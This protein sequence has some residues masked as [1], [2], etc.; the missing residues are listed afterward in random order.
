VNTASDPVDFDYDGAS[1]AAM[2]KVSF[3]ALG[4]SGHGAVVAGGDVDGDA[5]E[6]IVVGRGP[7]PTQA[8]EAMGFDFDATAVAALAGFDVTPYT[9]LYGA[10]VTAGDVDGDGRAE[11]VMGPGEAPSAAASVRTFRYAASALAPIAAGAFD[12]FPSSYGVVVATGFLG[13]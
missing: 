6:E 4:G 12:A 5:F 13:F 2:G 9:T 8:S 10:R 11:L 7:G 1:V 3:V